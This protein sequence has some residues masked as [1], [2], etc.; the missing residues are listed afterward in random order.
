MRK[1]MTQAINKSLPNELKNEIN[2]LQAV[3]I[4]KDAHLNSM[5][6]GMLSLQVQLEIYQGKS[7]RLTSDNSFLKVRVKELEQENVIRNTEL[8]A[9]SQLI[10]KAEEINQNSIDHQLKKTN[11]IE[12]Q[13]NKIKSQLVQEMKVNTSLA[14]KV[15][16][17]EDS[18]HA[19]F[20]EL[21]KLTNMLEVS[22]RKLMNKDLDLSEYKGQ[23]DKIKNSFTW[24]TVAPARA[25]SKKFKK[26]NANGLLSQQIET[27]KNSGL[28]SIDWYRKHCPE[29]DDLSLSPVEHYLT[30]GFKMGLTPSE[31]FNGNDYLLRYPDVQQEGVNPLLHYLTFGKNEGRTI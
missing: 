15:N 11:V 5:S 28:F 19:R 21:A 27:I 17:L 2:E 14:N 7:V 6:E 4:E 20:S 16:E 13:L 8:A 12:E 9:L 30:V 1:K 3:L 29:V 24:K 22:D 23:L 10:M 31:R 18:L 26:K 25:L